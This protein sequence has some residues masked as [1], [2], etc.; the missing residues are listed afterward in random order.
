MKNPEE[1]LSA[2]EALNHEWIRQGILRRKNSLNFK[3]QLSNP[4]VEN[5]K[6][7]HSNICALEDATINYIEHFLLKKS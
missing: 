7:E 1:R 6:E 4:I 3:K 2:E 5:I